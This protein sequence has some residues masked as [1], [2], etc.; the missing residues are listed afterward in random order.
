VSTP[1]DTPRTSPYFWPT[2]ITKI[3]SGEEPCRYQ[4]WYK[5]HYKYAKVQEDAES[6][7]RLAQYNAEHT[8]A[9]HAEADRLRGKGYEIALEDQAAF[10][11]QGK[12][13]AVGGKM[14][15][16]AY[17]DGTGEVVDVKTGRPSGSHRMQVIL[18]LL[19][20]IPRVPGLSHL[21]GKLSGRVHYP[22]GQDETIHAADAERMRGPIVKLL[23]DLSASEPPPAAP[24]RRSCQFCDILLCSHRY[25]AEDA[26]DAPAPGF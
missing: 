24:S 6:K 23:T 18:Y 3:L 21:S 10:V 5:G 11:V 1:A 13:C 19:F 17:K 7:A 2:W 20:G 14:D 16:V 26:P 4:G 8:A 12:H 9:L 22:K 25:K 15:L